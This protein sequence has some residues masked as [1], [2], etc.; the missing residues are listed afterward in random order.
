MSPDTYY[1]LWCVGLLVACV[2]LLPAAYFL[3]RRCG[4]WDGYHS[5]L[6]AGAAVTDNAVADALRRQRQQMSAAAEVGRWNE[7]AAY[8]A[9]LAKE[10]TTVI[11]RINP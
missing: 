11:E 7:D 6:R 10:E 5:G 9:M 1:T 2:I 4:R 8:R 3:G